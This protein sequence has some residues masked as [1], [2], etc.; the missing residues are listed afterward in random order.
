M[1]DP[2]AELIEKLKTVD[3]NKLSAS[4]RSISPDDGKY[5]SDSDKLR[6][7]LSADAEWKTCAYI[8]YLLLKTRYE[9]DI[10]SKEEGKI[11]KNYVTEE[12][13]NKLK[14]VL[15]SAKTTNMNLLEDILRHDQLAVIEELGRVAGQEIKSLLHPGTTSYDVLDTARSYLIKESWFKVVR[16]QIKETI[17]K[18][19]NLSERTMDVIMVG[20]THLQHT[21]PVTFGFFLSSYAARLADRMKLCDQY[22]GDLRGKI[23]GIVG[24]GAGIEQCVGCDSL[25]FEKK[26]LFNLGLE[27]DYTATQIVMKE[28]LADVGHGLVSLA[29]V[30]GDFA[31][32]MR[33]LYSSD[34]NEVTSMSNSKKLGLSSTDANKNNPVNW[35]N[36]AGTIPVIES[37][38]RVLYELIQSDLQRDL[39]GSVQARYQPHGMIAETYRI[40]KKA[41]NAIDDIGL[42][43][44]SIEKN[45]ANVRNNPSEA[46][47]TILRGEGF[48]HS[49]LGVGHKFVTEMSIKVRKNKSKLVDE[50]LKDEEFKS[51][52]ESLPETKKRIL[53]GELELYLGCAKQK[54]LM[55]INYARKA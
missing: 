36:I 10:K 15:S 29:R 50:S 52:Y 20:R 32:D 53:N 2:L 16:N 13:V 37:G 31:N 8:Q 17:D 7:Y 22:F 40:F 4:L 14:E 21:S 23:S 44:D 28:R 49:K 55:N 45:L 48:I 3:E 24:T 6:D 34:I 12:Q 9:F 35:E 38:M 47:V 43:N 54:T 46:T 39:R 26:L 18:L 51:M 27:P 5:A 42:V 1:A 41:S 25:E 33:I 30:L 19:C 11:K